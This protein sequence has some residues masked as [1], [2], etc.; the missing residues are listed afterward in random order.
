MPRGDLYLEVNI[1]PHPFFNLDK[2]DIYLKLPIT[3]WEAALGAK[4]DVPTLDGSVQMNLPKN[5]Q[6]EKKMLL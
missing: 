6:S 1:E 4:I 5:S 2:K 3:P